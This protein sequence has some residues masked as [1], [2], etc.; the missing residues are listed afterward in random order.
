MPL[1]KIECEDRFFIVNAINEEKAMQNCKTT[2]LKKKYTLMDFYRDFHEKKTKIY[3]IQ[4]YS[5]NLF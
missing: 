4:F 5:K 1:F 2:Y 3:K